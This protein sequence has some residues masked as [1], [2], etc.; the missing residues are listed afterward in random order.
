MMPNLP[1][2]FARN[3]SDKTDIKSLQ[4]T[5]MSSYI[6]DCLLLYYAQGNQDVHFNHIVFSSAPGD[7]RTEDLAVANVLAVSTV[8]RFINLYIPVIQI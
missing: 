3:I 7:I 2:A 8:K 6:N 1:Q 5:C 4:A